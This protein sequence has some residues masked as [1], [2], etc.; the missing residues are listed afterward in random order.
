MH[1]RAALT[2]STKQDQDRDLKKKN[3][4][5]E[6][7]GQGQ[8]L[9][10][11]DIRI[12]PNQDTKKEEEDKEEESKGRKD[13]PGNGYQVRSRRQKNEEKGRNTG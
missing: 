1:K 5:G 8:Q 2:R 13:E 10:V 9:G 11:I 6:V 3:S 4:R 7:R 12:L